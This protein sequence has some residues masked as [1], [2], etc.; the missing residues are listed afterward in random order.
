MDCSI[1]ISIAMI[2]E[3]TRPTCMTQKNIYLAVW[4]AGCAMLN[5]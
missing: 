3:Q 5:I 1:G 4:T 2:A